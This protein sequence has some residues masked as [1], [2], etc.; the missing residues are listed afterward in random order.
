[1]SLQLPSLDFK[2][3]QN[4]S[5]FSELF[6]GILQDGAD[7][8]LTVFNLKSPFSREQ[9]IDKIVRC[10]HDQGAFVR[11][12]SPHKDGDFGIYFELQRKSTRLLSF[13]SQPGSLRAPITPS[14]KYNLME[15]LRR[16]TTPEPVYKGNIVVA[17]DFGKSF[18]E[19][20]VASRNPDLT[21]FLSQLN[22]NS[23]EIKV[24]SVA[25]CVDHP[26]KFTSKI[27]VN[28]ILNIGSYARS[29]GYEVKTKKPL[30]EVVIDF[31]NQLGHQR[32][33]GHFG[34]LDVYQSDLFYSPHLVKVQNREPHKYRVILYDLGDRN[35]YAAKL[36]CK[37]L[38]YL[39]S[40]GAT[41]PVVRPYRNLL[42]DSQSIC[43]PPFLETS[44][45]AISISFPGDLSYFDKRDP[46]PRT[47]KL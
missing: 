37:I 9:T 40:Q 16:R 11:E 33:I 32:N 3:E 14:R 17:N 43:L 25:A 15:K 26:K 19:C 2:K 31:S 46:R 1:M 28:T 30:Y 10:M 7:S 36:N 6:Q 24:M 27:D 12:L 8:F 42:E 22:N 44:N 38:E 39:A 41:T 35:E 47:V 21:Q 45:S 18:F 13:Q 5:E 4:S 34:D 20:A 23:L 29:L